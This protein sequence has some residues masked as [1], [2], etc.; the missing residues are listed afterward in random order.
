MHPE[1]KK[2]N[3]PRIFSVA[4]RNK[5]R[6][7]GAKLSVAKFQHFA[8]KKKENAPRCK[9]H[10][11]AD[12]INPSIS[13]LPKDRRGTFWG[14]FGGGPVAAYEV[15]DRPPNP[16]TVGK[17]SSRPFQRYIGLGVGNGLMTRHGRPKTEGALRRTFLPALKRYV[18]NARSGSEGSRSVES[19]LGF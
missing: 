16:Y 8:P 3:A 14:V 9:M 7:L 4:P 5:N 6:I 18:E 19:Q 17:Y 2:E 15:I 10:L 1:T 13:L 12:G 11:G